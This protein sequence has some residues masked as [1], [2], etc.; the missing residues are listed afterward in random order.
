MEFHKDQFS[1]TDRIEYLRTPLAV[2]AMHQWLIRYCARRE[3]SGVIVACFGWV[4]RDW[5]IATNN[6]L[7]RR[8][9]L[10]VADAGLAKWHSH[11]LVIE[12]YDVL[13]ERECKRA[14]IR[15]KNWRAK[16]NGN[17]DETPSEVGNKIISDTPP[18]THNVTDLVTR[19]VSATNSDQ[20][21]PV[22]T[23]P[24]QSIS[25]KPPEGSE[26]GGGDSSHLDLRSEEARFIRRLQR[27][28]V[29]SNESGIRKWKDLAMAH[30][31]C[32]RFEQAVKCVTWSIETARKDGQV[33]DHASQVIA[34]AKRWSE[35]H[36]GEAS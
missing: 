19:N 17:G 23:R 27:L 6:Q 11:D 5:A 22:Q 10:K 31:G 30:G 13:G 24:V 2:Q 7:R 1:L 32:T 33:V 36:S 3:T 34:Y 15:M 4:D 9:V 8:D 21:R 26:V 20:S 12:G 16:K 28:L 35:I 18:V 29:C 14:R 25:P